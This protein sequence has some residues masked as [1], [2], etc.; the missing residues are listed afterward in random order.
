VIFKFFYKSYLI[1]IWNSKRMGMCMGIRIY[2]LP[3]RNENKSK[4]VYMMDLRWKWWWIFI[5]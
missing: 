5:I 2:P 3:S 4:V 1:D